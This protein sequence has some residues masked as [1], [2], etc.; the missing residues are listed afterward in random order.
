M[1]VKH[2][3]ELF[4]WCS[5]GGD[6]AEAVIVLPSPHGEYK[7]GISYSDA[8]AAG[9][10]YAIFRE[11]GQCDVRTP[12]LLGNDISKNLVLVGG[13]KANPIAKNFQ[14]L[15][16]GSLRFDLDNGVIYD[17]EK[18]V[19]L[20][21]E[22]ASGQ[23]RTISNVSA[24]YG[25][26]VYTDNPLGKSTKILQLA[27]IKGFGTLAAAIGLVDR[28]PVG[29]IDKLL[30]SLKSDRERN[31]PKNQTIEILIK[32]SVINGRARRDSIQVEKVIVTNGRTQR[33]WESETYKQL[34]TVGPNR[35][36]LNITKTPL[37]AINIKARIGD[38]E[39]SFGQSTDRQNAIYFL[40]KQ[41]RDD[42]L[43]QSDNKGWVNASALAERL[44]QIKHRDGV[45][46]LPDEIKRQISETIKRWANHLERRGE[47]ILS[48]K[49]K[50]D[51]N[52]I[53]SEILVFDS[54]IR[55]KIVDLVHMIN[56]EEKNRLA[57]GLQLIESKP[58]LGYRIN[59]HPALI[60]IN[61]SNSPQSSS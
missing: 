34:K 14:A 12:E 20:V 7:S 24:D 25:L 38:R 18:E 6:Q 5:L 45:V 51:S 8:L 1:R 58:R 33:K 55:K 28:D 39:I 3:S 11:L 13:P 4:D 16:R 49:I 15:K 53:N 61:E 2:F 50:L 17:K 27:G 47:L 60:F 26:I 54:D 35:L 41:A 21:P 10:I 46:D 48:D 30:R 56:H 42:Y 43:N 52:Y 32:V 36:H 59:L 44:W 37:K 57:P 9:E 40:A 31:Q 19:V 23:E 22:Y 29:Q